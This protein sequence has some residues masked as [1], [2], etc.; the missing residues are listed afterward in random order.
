MEACASVNF[1]TSNW[2]IAKLRKTSFFADEQIHKQ[3]KEPLLDL[4][5][6]FNTSNS[7]SF[8]LL[9]YK[10]LFLLHHFTI[11]LNFNKEV[12]VIQQQIGT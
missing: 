5:I 6:M 7:Q 8:Y 1:Y 9:S 10:M 4:T 2:K 3:S 11:T 12:K